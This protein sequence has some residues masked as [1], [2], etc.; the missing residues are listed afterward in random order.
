MTKRKKTTTNALKILDRI[1]G[2]D[3]HLRR[4]IREERQNLAVAH[5]IIELRKA[6]GLSQR[7]LAAK[8]GTTQSVISRL[9][10]ADYDG[11]SL[12]MLRRIAEVAGMKVDV[13]FLKVRSA[14]KTLQPA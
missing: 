2:D 14:P 11:H 6:A 9:E 7:E 13:R 1:T 3:P 8:I 4:E 10:D 5:K 12:T